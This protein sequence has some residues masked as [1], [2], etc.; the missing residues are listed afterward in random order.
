[1]K[2]FHRLLVNT[3]I[4][5]V[6]TS[7]LWFAVTF[8]VYLETRSVLATSVIGG[9][10]AIFSAFFGI[11]FGTFVD[12]H[13]KWTSMMVASATGLVLYGIALAQYAIVSDESLLSL[14]SAHFWLFVALI[15]GGSVIGNLRAIAMS[16]S[17]TLLVPEEH[18]TAPTACSAP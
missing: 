12:R 14:G 4:S 11:L 16:T 17:V 15:L 18:R 1:M 6:M 13:R 2:I 10:F 7:F 3:L 8:W 5:G 9:A